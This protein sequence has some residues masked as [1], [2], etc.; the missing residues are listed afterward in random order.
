M[1]AKST[2]SNLSSIFVVKYFEFFWTK[3]LRDWQM[4]EERE[5]RIKNASSMDRLKEDDNGDECET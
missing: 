3:L 2:Q 5:K 1:K 4:R